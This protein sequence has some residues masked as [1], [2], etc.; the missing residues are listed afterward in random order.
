MHGLELAKLTTFNP[1]TISPDSNL[2]D[3]AWL[4][5][6]YAI[7]HLPVVGPGFALCGIVS[8]SDLTRAGDALS[9]A[10]PVG[11]PQTLTAL[12]RVADVM[13]RDV[14]TIQLSDSTDA[15]LWPL[16]Y[17]GFHSVPV[18][19][20]E[21]LAGIIT[22]TDFLRELAEGDTPIARIAVA[23]HMTSGP[24][25]T[26]ADTPIA[27]ARHMM[28]EQRQDYLTVLWEGRVVGVVSDRQLRR[29]E[30]RE[31]CTLGPWSGGHEAAEYRA[32]AIRDLLP[33]TELRVRAEQTLAEAAGLMVAH[34]I[35][36]LPIVAA[37]GRF[38]GILTET[39]ILRMLSVR[40]LDA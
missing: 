33:E 7:H 15:A 20:E 14:Y 31:L 40:D 10:V 6:E 18:V 4:M 28:L 26:T 8:D 29:A 3:A 16:L 9:L 25:A 11:T 21:R 19:S 35:Q 2:A 37:D 23:R 17:Y 32:T 39:D 5:N 30:L 13:V 27:E 38:L 12:E 22:S 1:V 34:R 24:P 36:G